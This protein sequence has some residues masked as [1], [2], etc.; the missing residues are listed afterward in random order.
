MKQKNYARNR[1]IMLE[2][3]I[4]LEACFSDIVLMLIIQIQI[5]WKNIA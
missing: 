4:M 1:K 3:E 2:T 5:K